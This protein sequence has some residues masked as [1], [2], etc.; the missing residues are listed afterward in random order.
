MR[1]R[2]FFGIYVGLQH[3]DLVRRAVA[4]KQIGLRRLGD[5]LPRL[6]GL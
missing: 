1:L 2:T 5:L 4:E 6:H 3:I